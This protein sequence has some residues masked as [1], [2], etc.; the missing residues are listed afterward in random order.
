MSGC[1]C[2][3]S[4]DVAPPPPPGRDESGFDHRSV[5]E[6][7]SAQPHHAP[8]RNGWGRVYLERRRWA[9]GFAVVHGQIRPGATVGQSVCPL[10]LMFDLQRLVK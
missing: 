9:H 2:P 8:A 7:R 10:Q 4:C 3:G 1:A 5:R 6:P